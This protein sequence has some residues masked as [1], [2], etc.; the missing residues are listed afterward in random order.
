MCGPDLASAFRPRGSAPTAAARGGPHRVLVYHI[1]SLGDTLMALPALWGLRDRWLDARWTLLTKR[2]PLRHVIV[3]D[4]VLDGMGLFT[5][6]MLYSGQREGSGTLPQ[7]LKQAALL[8][9][10]RARRF[11]TVVYL[12][13]SDRSA[14]QV[15]RDRRFFQLA[16][17]PRQVGFDGFRTPPSRE[18]RPLPTLPTEAQTLRQRLCCDGLELAPVTSLRRDCAV[19]ETEFEQVRAWLSRQDGQD[20]GRPWLAL[21]P[22]SNMP[23]K[24]WP[25]ERYVAVALALVQEFD[26]WPVVFG[27]AEDQAR[28]QALQRALG[29]AHVA[30][31][32]LSP[33]AAAAAMRACALYLGNDT[34]T[35]HLAASEDVP[36]VVPFSARDFPGKW[37]P[38]G[39]DHV[40]IRRRPACEGCM[41]ERCEAQGMRCL[42]DI[43]V[44][45]VL[46]AARKV[47]AQ[48]DN[49]TAASA[50]GRGALSA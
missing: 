28:A 12:A 9:R 4:A 39:R 6:V 37:H 11:D 15:R 18:Q 40:I 3:A 19:G 17:I 25:L 48:A 35:M 23:A 49:R 31:G 24:V 2:T 38:M 26:L 46:D 21:A 33:R 7:R 42:L 34:G 13:P 29:G 27:G 30:A 22:G 45:E 10:L 41:L 43:G 14:P 47:L 1:G 8:L 44:P 32:A 16:G 50:R 36:C 5:D 20:R